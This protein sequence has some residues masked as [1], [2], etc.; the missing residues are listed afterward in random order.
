MRFSEDMTHTNYERRIAAPDLM[1]AMRLFVSNLTNSDLS[2]FEIS[3]DH[4]PSEQVDGSEWHTTALIISQRMQHQALADEIG[5]RISPTDKKLRQW[6][7]TSKEYR[8]SFHQ[9][10]FHALKNYPL[11]AV[12]VSA[13]ER[14]ILSHEQQ[15]AYELGVLGHY[16]RINQH[17]KAKVEFGPFFSGEN[18]TPRVLIVSEKHAPMAIFTANLLLRIHSLLSKEISEKLGDTQFLR[19]AIWSDKPPNDF[20]GRY[21]DLMRLLLGSGNAQRKFTWGGFTGNDDQGIDLL[22]DNLAGLFNEITLHPEHNEYRGEELQ[23]PTI[24]VFCWERF[25]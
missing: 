5:I 15:L 2:L 13:K 23:P 20:T 22:A 25:E 18:T 6:K 8:N 21:A 4:S 9:E 3:I 12:V 19:I 1:S 17:G 24:G 14:S 16:K 10:F 11:L 7:N